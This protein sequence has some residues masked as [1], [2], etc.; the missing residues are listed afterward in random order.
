MGGE[1]IK[2]VR[3]SQTL[4]LFRQSQLKQ[5]VQILNLFHMINW[6]GQL[7]DLSTSSY[8]METTFP[9]SY[10]MT[11]GSSVWQN[12][13]SPSIFFISRHFVVSQQFVSFELD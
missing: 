9:P 8:S 7:A 1:V 5:R 11:N 10:A 2:N 6:Q 12:K 4:A 13:A 3:S